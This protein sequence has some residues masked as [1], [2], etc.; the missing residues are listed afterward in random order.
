MES[1]ESMPQSATQ[2]QVLVEEF[3]RLVQKLADASGEPVL[4]AQT[5]ALADQIR[6]RLPANCRTCWQ[7][8]REVVREDVFARN[9]RLTPH[10]RRHDYLLRL[11]V[12]QFSNLLTAEPPP[13]PPPLIPRISLAGMGKFFERLLGRF[14]YGDLNAL[15]FSLLRRFPHESDSALRSILFASPELRVATIKVLLTTLLAMRDIRATRELFKQHLSAGDSVW[16]VFTAVDDHFQAVF[17]LL[18][19]HVLDFMQQP[20]RT[21]EIERNFGYAATDQILDIY[22]AYSRMLAEDVSNKATA[23]PAPLFVAAPRSHR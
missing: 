23:A 4:A 3:M 7:E 16:T 1:H 9:I 8:I 20:S 13:C 15:S 6:M 12:A 21:N 17:D 18:F 22:E 11:L 2:N 10:D 14:A 19:A 5:V